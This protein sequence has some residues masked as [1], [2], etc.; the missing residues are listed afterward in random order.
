M[1]SE[2]K[3]SDAPN[4]G[5]ENLQI[6]P[7]GK[8]K[9][10]TVAELAGD[11]A[12]CDWLIAQPWFQERFRPIYQIIVQGG[13]PSEDTPEHNRIQAKFFDDDFCEAFTTA[14]GFR[15]QECSGDVW[16]RE[17][18][19]DAAS[20]WDK[21][22]AKREAGWREY[23]KRARENKEAMEHNRLLELEHGADRS[24]WHPWDVGALRY[25][26]HLGGK[27]ATETE[28]WGYAR[29][30]SDDGRGALGEY[31]DMAKQKFD[32]WGPAELVETEIVSEFSREAEAGV[33][34]IR[35]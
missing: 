6:V 13:P 28:W 26:N 9:D 1:E 2:L 33:S 14:C 10:R 7:F 16:L 21:F 31:Y 23:Q 5:D 35:Y 27:F 34:N 20:Q 4:G 19:A 32:R 15:R 22:R 3:K 12:Y 29:K 30:I 11:R 18:K 17:K 8:Y 25:L 24:K